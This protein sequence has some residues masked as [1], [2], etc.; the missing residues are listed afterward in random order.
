MPTVPLRSFGDNLA[1]GYEDKTMRASS[2]RWLAAWS[3]LLRICVQTFFTLTPLAWPSLQIKK[4][5]GT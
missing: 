2:P 1:T 4:S 5:V 3:P